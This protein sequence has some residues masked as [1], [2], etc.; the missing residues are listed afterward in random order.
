MSRFYDT[1][2]LPLNLGDIYQGRL[3]GFGPEGLLAAAAA[4]FP[5]VPGFGPP[6]PLGIPPGM[7]GMILPGSA[8]GEDHLREERGSPSSSAGSSHSSPRSKYST[9]KKQ[10]RSSSTGQRDD[11]DS[12]QNNGSIEGKLLLDQERL[13]MMMSMM[14]SNNN[15]EDGEE[16]SQATGRESPASLTGSEN[17]VSDQTVTNDLMS[18][19][20]IKE[21]V[22]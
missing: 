14:P 16:E 3:P 18:E 21:A 17:H 19:Q 20:V 2:G 1:Q 11:T 6:F 12:L 7:P 10:A 15:R 9:S 13:R 4:G 8:P 22:V 5:G